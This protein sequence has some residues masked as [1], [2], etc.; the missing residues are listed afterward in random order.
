MPTA[1]AETLGPGTLK[2]GATGDEQEF[3]QQCS[4]VRLEP[5]T[6]T[7]DSVPVLSGE[8]I[9]GDSTETWVIAGTL[10]QRYDADALQDWCFDNRLTTM[11]FTFTPKEG[12]ASSWKG[13][14]KITA[15]TIGGDVKVKNT[16]DFEFTLVG[17]PEKVAGSSAA[18]F[19]APAVVASSALV[20]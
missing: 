13:Q 16:S 14:A 9:D 8:E 12:A 4:N 1:K 18:A 19:G 5:S 7:D 15:I 2:F 6:D 3:A 20:A 11:P 10:Y 17:A